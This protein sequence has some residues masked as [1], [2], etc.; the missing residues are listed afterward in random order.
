[1]GSGHIPSPV[2]PLHGPEMPGDWQPF[3]VI[4]R[5]IIPRNNVAQVQLLIHWQ[6]QTSDDATWEDYE[7]FACK[8][9]NFIREGTNF[10]EEGAMR[11]EIAQP[12]M[13]LE[14]S[15]TEELEG[16]GVKTK[17]AVRANMGRVGLAEVDRPMK[18]LK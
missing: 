2:I 5:R 17:L 9:S 10:L 6:H 15:D 16:A 7:A 8:F 18:E 13:L 11:R 14:V 12:G 1:V 3:K 4:G